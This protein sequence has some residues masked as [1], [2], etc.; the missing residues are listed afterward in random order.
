MIY[1]DEDE[2]LINRTEKD[3]PSFEKTFESVRSSLAFTLHTYFA[4]DVRENEDDLA[5]NGPDPESGPV[6]PALDKEWVEYELPTRK[7]K[8]ASMRR[9]GIWYRQHQS[10][11]LD[12]AVPMA[13]PAQAEGNDEVEIVHYM[14]KSARGPAL[15]A[16][17]DDDVSLPLL[18]QAIREEAEN[19]HMKVRW[20]YD[21]RRGMNGWCEREGAPRDCYEQNGGGG[22][23]LAS[24]MWQSKEARQ[25]DALGV[26]GGGGEPRAGRENQR[27]SFVIQP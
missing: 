5:P 1:Y 10:M 18:E 24:K 4:C 19:E 22:G 23:K 15:S 3:Y 7:S 9:L 17:V 26:R 25:K 27:S 13:I 14:A 11:P 16:R 8:R 2:R 6:I 12:A 20:S 21:S